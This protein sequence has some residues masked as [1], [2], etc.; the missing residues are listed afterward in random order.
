[1]INIKLASRLLILLS[2]LAAFTGCYKDRTIIFES[3]PEVTRPVGFANDII[4][5][6]NKSCN[7]SGCH[8]KGGQIPDLTAAN[9]YNALT[10]GNYMDKSTVANSLL[11][12][13]LTGNKGTP[14]PVSG[15]NKDYN[16]LVLAWL[17]QGAKNN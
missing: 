12:L 13:K 15:I 7:T 17:K 3:G 16:S 6:F 14:M 2:G 5:I 10:I 1:M 11:Y 8:S 4:P 9:A